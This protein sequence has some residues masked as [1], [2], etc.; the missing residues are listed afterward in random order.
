[1][2]TAL[3]YL[4]QLHTRGWVLVVSTRKI[5][6]PT[7]KPAGPINSVGHRLLIDGSG[8]PSFSRRS[9]PLDMR[10]AIFTAAPPPLSAPPRT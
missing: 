2:N 4:R 7:H 5:V 8:T 9:I 1:M 10:N 3:H 6:R